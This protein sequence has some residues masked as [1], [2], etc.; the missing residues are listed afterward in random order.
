LRAIQREEKRKAGVTKGRKGSSREKPF[1]SED[2]QKKVKMQDQRGEGRA[3]GARH[4][5]AGSK[6]RT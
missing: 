2:K 1:L 4:D 6:A 5:A 3:R